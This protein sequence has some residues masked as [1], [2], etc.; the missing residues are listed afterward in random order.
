MSTRLYRLLSVFWYIRD[1]LFCRRCLRCKKVAAV[2]YKY[3]L[4]LDCKNFCKARY[5]QCIRCA[6]NLPTGG[7]QCGRCLV[8]K[9]RF[10]QAVIRAG[11]SYRGEI[12]QRI[13]DL[14]FL[15][16]YDEAKVIASMLLENILS[17]GEVPE[18]DM[19]IAV[20]MHW[21]KVAV[22]GYNQSELIAK[23][24][25]KRMGIPFAKRAMVKYRSTP[26]QQ[27]KTRKERI[28]NV[29]NT[30]RA[31]NMVKGKRVLLI[32]DVLTTGATIATCVNACRVQE[33]Y[34]IEAWV[35]AKSDQ[36]D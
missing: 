14:K 2:R 32:D 30:M 3:L 20:P 35:V 34:N 18:F 1:S 8:Q 24:I 17:R 21:R 36:I 6:I 19:V 16:R 25:A 33:V 12:K 11:F 22:R 27:G 7:T 4:C 28:K 10:T 23:Q 31:N 29:K 15:Y 13:I 5:D 26:S 9:G